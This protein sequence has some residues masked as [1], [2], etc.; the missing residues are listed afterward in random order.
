MCNLPPFNVARQRQL[1]DRE[2]KTLC[3]RPRKRKLSTKKHAASHLDAAHLDDYVK[4][5]R[6]DINRTRSEAPLLLLLLSLLSLLPGSSLFCREGC[7]LRGYII[8]QVTQ[9]PI[10]PV[11]ANLFSDYILPLILIDDLTSA[12]GR[13][14]W[15]ACESAWGHYS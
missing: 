2:L 15:R 9:Y 10:S 8:F 6:I 11:D 3:P 4:E 14:D 1:K 5:E 12:E 13:C 7:L